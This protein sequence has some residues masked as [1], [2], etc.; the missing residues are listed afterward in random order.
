MSSLAGND[1]RMSTK[2]HVNLQRST[3]G[4]SS[5]VSVTLRGTAR[6]L[7]SQLWLWP[8]LA[9]A[10]L[11]IV[12]WWVQYRIE[13]TM[14][15]QSESH[16]QALLAVDV[17]ALQT[18]LRI[19]EKDAAEASHVREIRTGAAQLVEVLKTS[20]ESKSTSL[21]RDLLND[22]YYER[23]QQAISARIAELGYD[24]YVLASSDGRLLVTG[25]N[26]LVGYEVKGDRREFFDR[27]LKDGPLVSRPTASI[28]PVIDSNT[29]EI[30]M[31]SPV[32]FAAA[33][34]SS[35]EDQPVAILALRMRP[36]GEFS[37]IL[38]AARFGNSG[39][40]Y[41]FNEQGLFLSQSRFDPELKRLG[42]LDDKPEVTSIL[43]L[44]LRDPGVNLFAGQRARI[45]RSE[46]PLTGTAQQAIRGTT[47]VDV[48]GYRDYR[49]V[50]SIAAW[51]WLPRYNFGVATKVD[52]D[53]AFAPLFSVRRFIWFLLGLLGLGAVAIYLFM[54][55][56]HRQQRELQKA[57]LS[58][59]KLGQYSLEEKIGSGGM[60]TVYRARHRFLRRPT[61]VKLLDPEK[62]T[63]VAIGRFE[64]EVQLTSQLTHPNTIA[65]YDYGHT[66]EGLFYYVMELLEGMNLDDL[67][68][69][70][71][72]QPEGRVASILN[73]ACGSLAEAHAAGL[74]HRDIK[75]ANIYLT[76]RGGVQDYVKVLD[77]GLAKDVS[78]AAAA[79]VTAAPS[80]TGTPL[81]LA[82]E[83]IQNP[84]ISNSRSDVY[85]LGAVAYYLLTGT[86]VF[87]G[88]S[89]IDILSAHVKQAPEPLSQRLG[90]PVDVALE[91]LVMRCLAKDP[92]ERPADAH[93]LLEELAACEI[94]P[95]SWMESRAWWRK[96][97]ASRVAVTETAQMPTKS[98]LDQTIAYNQ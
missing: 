78:G 36:E 27:V 17:D 50:P 6:L 72:A 37:R 66:D 24:D 88:N 85:A 80:L 15:R 9:A 76:T 98:N 64:R 74:V 47:D 96:R 26:Q 30:R 5:R 45:A 12:G 7:R 2:T 71:G 54:V 94:R 4:A 11:A 51:T 10:F 84:E 90:R 41:A 46:M 44:E 34:V 58:A 22:P 62:V 79:N 53:E 77:F 70:Y 65:I 81:Y 43:T 83:T 35:N 29:G 31:G 82:P 55:L 39:E 59:R 38:T 33:P 73:Q 20:L 97:E 63:E 23:V 28:R 21:D 75:P 40:T 68:R 57:A 42:L 25:D 92:Q 19:A 69:D 49:G 32:M 95:W 16:L 60:G 86:T 13:S 3:G 1:F 14:Q 87:R 91:A 93:A 48:R 67:V 56:L 61:A 8:L 18:W 89:I 52:Y